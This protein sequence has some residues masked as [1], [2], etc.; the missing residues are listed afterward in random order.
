MQGT[1]TNYMAGKLSQRFAISILSNARRSTQTM[2]SSRLIVY[3]IN[4]SLFW[5]VSYSGL[6]NYQYGQTEFS[7]SQIDQTYKEM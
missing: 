6:N 1:R 7:L 4:E 2:I 3:C 5:H